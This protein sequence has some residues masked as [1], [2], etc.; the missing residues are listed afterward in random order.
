MRISRLCLCAA[1]CWMQLCAQVLAQTDAADSRFVRFI[2]GVGNWQGELQ[3]AVV[4]YEND[5]G[6]GLDLVAAIHIGEASYYEALNSYFGSRDAVLYELIA[7]PDARPGP[8][9]TSG[10]TNNAGTNSNSSSGLGMVQQS[11]AAFL[12]IEFQL[13]KIDYSAAN[14][15]HADLSPTQLQEIMQAKDESFFS[16]FL[17]LAAAQMAAAQNRPVE[18]VPVSTFSL[19]ALIR[20]LLA[21]DQA[22]AFKYLFAEE[23]GRADSAFV[24]V[25]L[26]QQLTLLG[27]RN[28]VAIAVL[29]DT[30][31][32]SASETITLFYGAAHMP[33][34]EREITSSLGFSTVGR[35]WI[36]AWRIPS[37]VKTLRNRGRKVLGRA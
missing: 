18:D 6:I 8:G 1:L 13:E 20:A 16:M 23:L 35:R 37:W 7:E 15:I 9:N 3:T 27:D 5:Q 19:M 26:E 21:D 17:S 31:E 14:F 24:G 25:E 2:P 36:T 32:Q 11:L 10:G 4:S 28:R 12:D 22:N 33:G 29:E 34:L 30:L